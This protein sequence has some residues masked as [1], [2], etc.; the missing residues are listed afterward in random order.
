MGIANSAA[1]VT[2]NRAYR[3]PCTCTSVLL[4]VMIRLHIVGGK[5][6]TPSAEQLSRVA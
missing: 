2:V 4:S 3:Y 1:S 6:P 5:S